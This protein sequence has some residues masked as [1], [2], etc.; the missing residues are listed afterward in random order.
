MATVTL[1]D[2]PADLHRR[3]KARAE[4]NGRSLN[5]EM[6]ESLEASFQ[7]ERLDVDALLDKARRVRASI[8]ATTDARITRREIDR[9][10]REGRP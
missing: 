1:K 3:L 8:G 9:L 7:A 5:R 10:K 2:L 6:I 4:R